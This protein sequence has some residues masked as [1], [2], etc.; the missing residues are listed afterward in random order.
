MRPD[1]KDRIEAIKQKRVDRK[2]KARIDFNKPG[3]L[4]DKI[5]IIADYL[6]IKEPEE[7][8]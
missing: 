8:E 6:G 5:D 7:K 3:N 4:Q 1:L 2:E